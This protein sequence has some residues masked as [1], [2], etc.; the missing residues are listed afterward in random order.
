[1]MKTKKRSGESDQSPINVTSALKDPARKNSNVWFFDSPKNG[2]RMSILGDLSFIHA[3]LMEGDLGVV[4]YKNASAEII[5]LDNPNAIPFKAVFLVAFADGSH[6]WLSFSNDDGKDITSNKMCAL[7]SERSVSYQ[8]IVKSQKSFQG[9]EI[10]FDNWLN[11]CAMINRCR[12][13][14]TFKETD[15]LK[16]F[17]RL[18]SGAMLKDIFSIANLDRAKVLASIAIMLQNGILVADLEAKILCKNTIFSLKE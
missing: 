12:M 6:K 9:C 18:H 17:F 14:S 7:N 16:Q 3:V 4:S 15:A 10:L 11:L 1:M 13:M 5:E 2:R 8:H